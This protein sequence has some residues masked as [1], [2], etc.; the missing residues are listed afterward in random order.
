MKKNLAL[1]KK[2]KII[3]FKYH[4]SG[5]NNYNDIAID[6]LPHALSFLLYLYGKKINTINIYNKEIK[7]NNWNIFFRFNDIKCYFDFN[8]NHKK[9][10][11][12]LKISLDNINYLRIQKKVQSK[13]QNIEEYIKSG[14]KLKKIENVMKI[15]I[16]KNI[17]KLLKNRI[18]NNDIDIQKKIIFLMG[19]MLKHK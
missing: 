3:K 17:N 12:I 7:K 6:L 13:L 10:K 15:S 1:K 14:L 19:K 9:K 2:I 8:Q 11:S 4:T 18:T 16:N 5:K